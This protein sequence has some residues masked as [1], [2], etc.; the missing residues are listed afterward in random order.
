LNLTVDI[1][2]DYIKK[3]YDLDFKIETYGSHR[4]LVYKHKKKEYEF[5]CNYAYQEKED[6]EVWSIYD[7]FMDYE[8][9]HGYGGARADNGFDTVDEIMKE[10]GFEKNNQLK[11]F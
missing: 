3:E 1:I 7:D 11:L 5:Y 9:W 6:A 10:W 2:K 4:Q 8:K